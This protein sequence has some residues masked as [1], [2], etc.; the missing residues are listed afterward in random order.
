MIFPKP[1]MTKPA[2]KFTAAFSMFVMHM[3]LFMRHSKVTTPFTFSMLHL[4]TTAS[5]ILP[6]STMCCSVGVIRGRFKGACPT[7]RYGRHRFGQD[8]CINPVRLGDKLSDNY[9][10]YPLN[11][12][13]VWRA[14]SNP[15]PSEGQN[16]TGAR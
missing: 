13:G 8:R 1:A 14:G 11:T 10:G 4:R 16:D 6:L 15:D 7:F 12:L 3:L 2:F 9:F 5:V